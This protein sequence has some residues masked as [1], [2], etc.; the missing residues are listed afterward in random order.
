MCASVLFAALSL[1]DTEYFDKPP[2]GAVYRPGSQVEFLLDKMSDDVDKMIYAKLYRH[3]DM[4]SVERQES[5]EDDDDDDVNEDGDD[6][7]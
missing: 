3:D 4:P 1:A 2:A 5:T 7:R 6:T